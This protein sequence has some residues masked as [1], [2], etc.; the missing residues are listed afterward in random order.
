MLE[1]PEIPVYKK[2]FPNYANENRNN[3]ISV[4]ETARLVING[5]TNMPEALTSTKPLMLVKF[6]FVVM[7]LLFYTDFRSS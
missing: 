4:R 7:C 6:T 1:H 2:S 5:M 3:R